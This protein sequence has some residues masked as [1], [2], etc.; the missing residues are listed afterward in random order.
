MNGNYHDIQR[1]ALISFKFIFQGHIQSITEGKGF[2]VYT[3]KL[4]EIIKC[5]N[6][7]KFINYLD[8]IS[9]VELIEVN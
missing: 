7:E 1:G 4:F 9:G 5:I 2:G 3:G 6:N 8:H